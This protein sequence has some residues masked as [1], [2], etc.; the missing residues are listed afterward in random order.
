VLNELRRYNTIMKRL[1]LVVVMSLWPLVA[2]ADTTLPLTTT[3]NPQTSS[4]SQLQ[5][6]DPGTGNQPNMA[7]SQQ[8][9]EVQGEADPADVAATNRPLY[10]GIGGAA[11]VILGGIGWYASRRKL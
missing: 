9:L 8:V 7:P 6:G 4:A 10:L 2:A 1:I 3:T 5:A 11:L